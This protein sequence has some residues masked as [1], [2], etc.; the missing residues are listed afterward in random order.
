M[1][2]GGAIFSAEK[3]IL[4]HYHNNVCTL[5]LSPILVIFRVSISKGWVPGLQRLKFQLVSLCLTNQSWE[6]QVDGRSMLPGSIWNIFEAS[7]FVCYLE[8]A[9]STLSWKQSIGGIRG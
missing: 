9:V 8:F 6:C 5:Y 4:V 3:W 2:L 1:E 7:D